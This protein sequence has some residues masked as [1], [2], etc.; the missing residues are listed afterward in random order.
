[1]LAH[2]MHAKVEAF[3][4]K[5]QLIYAGMNKGNCDHMPTLKQTSVCGDKLGYNASKLQDLHKEFSERL[6][7]FDLVN[8]DMSIVSRP[9][10]F[11]VEG[12]PTHLQMEILD[13]QS[14][15]LLKDNFR[16]MSL[17]CFYASLNDATFPR[18]KS[19]ARKILVLFGSTY[20]CEQAFS[21]MKFIK[22]K[23]KSVM[24]DEH[25]DQL[26]RI[27]ISPKEPNFDK[28]IKMQNQLHCSH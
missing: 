14:D 7:D 23:S 4:A 26:M 3:K 19:L 22:D 5:L 8:V 12:I 18:L 28:L 21:R 13:F 20:V 2:N 24:T 9:F 27:A 1:M 16:E 15:N 6:G 10:S 11:E 17:S 25:L